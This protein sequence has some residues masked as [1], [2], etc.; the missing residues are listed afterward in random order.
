[1][2]ADRVGD[3]EPAHAVPDEGKLD[4]VFWLAAATLPNDLGV[5]RPYDL[6]Q[7]RYAVI[8]GP[9]VVAEIDDGAQQRCGQHQPG[10]GQA[11]H[12]HDMIDAGIVEEA[13]HVG[14]PMRVGHQV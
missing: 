1:K 10:K 3:D 2:H 4:V 8:A 9:I 7:I 12:R 14:R 6:N 13:G 11:S 5:D